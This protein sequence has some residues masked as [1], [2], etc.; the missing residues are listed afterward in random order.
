MRRSWLVMPLALVCASSA[1]CASVPMPSRV[2]SGRPASQA[3]QAEEPYVRLIPVG[4]GR[5]WTPN[6]IVSGF[7]TASGSF[8]DQHKV[9]REYLAPNVKW[10][11]DPSPQVTIY[12][13]DEPSL[14]TSNGSIQGNEGSV[15]VKGQTLGTISPDGQYKAEPVQQPLDQFFQLQKNGQGQWRIT[16]LPTLLEQ[17]LLLSDTDEMRTFRTRNLYYFAPDG[18]KLVPN[19]I[20]LPLLNRTDLPGQI[21]RAELNGPTEWLKDAVVSSFPVGTKLLSPVEVGGDGTATVNLSRQAAGG[22]KT[23]MYAQ[24]MWALSQLPEVKRLRLEI[25]GTDV[26][27]SA[28]D[29]SVYNPNRPAAGSAVTAF[30]R[31][32][33]GHVWELTGGGVTR[34]QT[35]ANVRMYNLAVSPDRYGY[36]AGLS[37]KSTQL[38]TA[39]PAQADSARVILTAAPGATFGQPSW[40]RHG[41][42]WV[43]ESTAKEST[44]WYKEPKKDPVKVS[45]WELGDRPVSAF[46]VAPDGVR[47]AAIGS[48]PADSSSIQIMLGR[49]TRD[50]LGQ[51][52]VDNFLPISSRFTDIADFGWASASDLVVLGS[53]QK[54]TSPQPYDVPI[55]GGQAAVI[56]IAPPV[57]SKTI[58]AAPG[59][60]VLIGALD[61]DDKPVLCRNTADPYSEWD[62][63]TVGN[64]AE[65][66]Y[67]G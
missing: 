37:A 40:D 61:K 28:E 59:Q 5:D 20:Y 12:S 15:E 49:I 27:M 63:S 33:E 55:S 24:L 14:D 43:V 39:D 6:Q 21:V 38:L 7:L 35:L 53:Q 32:A 4:P 67:P 16:G 52:K 48:N 58:T 34:I 50:R 57:S 17:G 44:L 1:G 46:R 66:A 2:V 42:L 36:I 10:T 18:Q 11:P 41:N 30:F 23:G 47:V 45:V 54:S 8:D 65:P 31:D 19:P 13:S 29:W 64:G 62:C 25:A 9:A 22:N 56:G 60:Q 51:P 3:Q 26:D